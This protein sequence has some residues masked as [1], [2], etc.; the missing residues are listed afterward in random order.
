MITIIIKTKKVEGYFAIVEGDKYKTGKGGCRIT[1]T[2][3]REEVERLALV[4]QKKIDYYNLPYCGA[5]AGIVYRKG[6]N[7]KRLI[8]EFFTELKKLNL[9]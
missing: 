5:K 9:I 7:K 2:V 1:S 3:S 8:K 6:Q 4:M